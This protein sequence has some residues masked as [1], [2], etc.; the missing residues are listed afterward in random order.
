MSKSNQLNLDLVL[1][2]HNLHLMGKVI[3]FPYACFPNKDMKDMR[4]LYQHPVQLLLYSVNISATKIQTKF[5]AGHPLYY[6]IW[7]VASRC[8]TTVSCF[9]LCH[10]HSTNIKK[11]YFLEFLTSRWE[12]RAP[13]YN[14]A[15][16][17]ATRKCLLPS[18][19]IQVWSSTVGPEIFA[20]RR[21]LRLAALCN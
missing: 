7:L 15:M 8:R 1:A 19:E 5:L 11:A 18:K 10:C 16:P 9:Y 4:Y 17:D 6:F 3:W 12:L 13:S 20:Y 14:V 21:W 2:I